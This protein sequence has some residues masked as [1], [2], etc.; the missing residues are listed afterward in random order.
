MTNGDLQKRIEASPRLTVLRDKLAAELTFRAD[1]TV[2]FD[3]LLVIAIISLTI[4][5]VKYC[6]EKR[7]PDEVKQDIKDIRSLPARKLIR[8]RRRAN[9]LW[10]DCCE[11]RQVSTNE[12]NPILTALYELGESTDDATLDE[13]IAL[14]NE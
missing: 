5:L 10:R 8:L 4:Q 13:L 3:P 2:T 6:R 11:D 1:N 14:A 9:M 7:T 12:P